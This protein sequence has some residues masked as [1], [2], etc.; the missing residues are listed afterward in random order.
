[1]RENDVRGIGR[2]P[3]AETFTMRD[4]ESAMLLEVMP[5]VVIETKEHATFARGEQRL[6]ASSISPAELDDRF[7]KGDEE[8]MQA[9]ALAR[10]LLR[11]TDVE[12]IRPLSIHQE[13]PGSSLGRPSSGTA[14]ADVSREIWGWDEVRVQASNLSCEPSFAGGG[15]AAIPDRRKGGGGNIELH[16][17]EFRRRAN[18]YMHA[19][20]G[21][22]SSATEINNA[23]GKLDILQNVM[24]K[25]AAVEKGS[26]V[27]GNNFPTNNSTSAQS[28]QGNL[29]SRS[30]ARDYEP[31]TLESLLDYLFPKGNEAMNITNE[32]LLSL[33]GAV[34]GLTLSVPKSGDLQHLI[35]RVTVT[36]LPSFS[37]LVGDC[38]PFVT[39]NDVENGSGKPI[40][41]AC[42]L[43]QLVSCFARSNLLEAIFESLELSSVVFNCC[44]AVN[45]NV[46]DS[47]D[48]S[49]IDR[50]AS[51]RIAAI[52]LNSGVLLSLPALKFQ[53]CARTLV[54][55][56]AGIIAASHLDERAHL[57]AVG[58][59]LK[60]FKHYAELRGVVLSLSIDSLWVGMSSS[61]GSFFKFDFEG[62]EDRIG[63]LP[64]VAVSCIQSCCD[65]FLHARSEQDYGDMLLWSNHFWAHIFHKW[66]SMQDPKMARSAI[67]FLVER[68]LVARSVPD[69][70]AADTLLLVM[71]KHLSGPLGLNNQ[72]VAVRSIAVE[73]LSSIVV[74]LL[75]SAS[76]MNK[77]DLVECP[78][79]ISYKEAPV[80]PQ[81]D[82][83][84][85]VV[86]YLLFYTSEELKKCKRNLRVM[87]A[88]NFG[89]DHFSAIRADFLSDLVLYYKA[90]MG[91]G[92][93]SI[94][95]D[96]SPIVGHPNRQSA[97][98]A[99]NSFMVDSPLAKSLDALLQSIIL[100]TGDINANV[101]SKTLKCLRPILQGNGLILLSSNGDAYTP[102]IT[103]LLDTS[104]SVREAA[105]GL[106]GESIAAHFELVNLHL[107]NIVLRLVDSSQNVRRRCIDVLADIAAQQPSVS[108]K[109]LSS[110][111]LR[112]RDPEQSIRDQVLNVFARLWFADCAKGSRDVQYIA[113][114]DAMRLS[115]TSL[116]AE[117]NLDIVKFASSLI[118][119]LHVV[120]SNTHKLLSEVF[121]LIFARGNSTCCSCDAF[122][123][124]TSLAA[125]FSVVC[126]HNVSLAFSKCSSLCKFVRDILAREA[127][128]GEESEARLSGEYGSAGSTRNILPYMNILKIML[129]ADHR[130]SEGGLAF[131]N[132][133]IVVD[134]GDDYEAKL[135]LSSM[136]VLEKSL[137][138]GLS[139][140]EE[141]MGTLLSSLQR[142]ILKSPHI[143]VIQTCA[144]LLCDFERKQACEGLDSFSR[145]KFKY[146][147][148][149]ATAFLNV[150]EKSR[151]PEDA[152]VCSR[153][154]LFR[155]L[156]VVGLL[157]RYHYP[158]HCY[159]VRAGA[160]RSDKCSM[161]HA[162]MQGGG[163]DC[164]L[165][166]YM[167]YMKVGDHE[168]RCRAVQGF[169]YLIV[170]RPLLL[171][172]DSVKA[173]VEAS[174]I[175]TS[176]A[177]IKVQA[178]KTL[179]DVVVNIST[180]GIEESSVHSKSN[181]AVGLLSL[182]Q[183]P[184]DL[185]PKSVGIDCPSSIP[186]RDGLHIGGFD[187]FHI[188]LLASFVD[189]SMSLLSDNSMETRLCALNLVETLILH[190][191]INPTSAISPLLMCIADESEEIVQRSSKLLSF[192]AQTH[193][194][195][196]QMRAPSDIS[197]LIRANLKVRSHVGE[198]LGLH[199]RSDL[200]LGEGRGFFGRILLAC[201]KFYESFATTRASRQHFV[202][203]IVKN[204]EPVGEED[205]GNATQNKNWDVE[206]IF[207][208]CLAHVL[209]VLPFKDRAE[210]LA[211]IFS[212]NNVLALHAGGL[213]TR[214]KSEARTDVMQDNGGAGPPY[215][216][217]SVQNICGATLPYSLLLMLKQ[218]L[219]ISF[220]IT[221][222]DV[223]SYRPS[224]KADGGK[225]A[226]R[227]DTLIFD[228]S[229]LLKCA[230]GSAT[231]HEAGNSVAALQR[232]ILFKKLMKADVDCD[233]GVQA[234]PAGFVVARRGRVDP[235]LEQTQGG[236]L[237]TSQSI[238]TG[239][240]AKRTQMAALVPQPLRVQPKRD[241]KA[242]F[243]Y[244]GDSS[245]VDAS[246]NE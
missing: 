137:S 37:R 95:S 18:S 204:F 180:V 42:T 236:P 158:L 34:H 89:E 246:E 146:S 28:G 43:L 242:K 149:L 19:G 29:G 151:N 108:A 163:V 179:L 26:S 60:M 183:N 118:N 124:G 36:D 30:K 220:D 70:P 107:D 74:H 10:E 4:K 87:H 134:S 195:F 223:K 155:A 81:L 59:L 218:F 54:G 47:T 55:T 106:L 214:L 172:D 111:L 178:L 6:L 9:M 8:I 148:R 76:V 161:C 85:H 1:M 12:H 116:S 230:S 245:D 7:R 27:G 147:V 208:N 58:A 112:I 69:W 122:S 50:A 96:A 67:I 105:V 3:Q 231:A 132:A 130:F 192:V 75:E 142:C 228:T 110:V 35:L 203:V 193:L 84:E 73:A 205:G 154:N 140:I 141:D 166:I 170:H 86:S 13:N 38:M 97:C 175:G 167:H 114:Y 72:H 227:D 181:A 168:L 139:W 22:R 117:E 79:T 184:A 182:L 31:I 52:V 68:L 88:W 82:S 120:D 103:R 221:E 186:D 145:D 101:R 53:D 102:I 25:L 144:K 244:L 185:S 206:L 152:K 99:T 128:Y 33:L 24:S 209:S 64:M 125:D 21:P 63:R 14:V 235:Y 177:K 215:N 66:L 44:E 83:R 169:F 173:V 165:P 187:G 115:Q 232:F 133:Y 129:C 65:E 93:D 61:S 17:D 238:I 217:A 171:N 138:S 200:A 212:I 197:S 160:M 190:G 5:E 199:V 224:D 202:G 196:I 77:S 127:Q 136:E 45:K 207:L 123:K 153:P 62:Q 233:F 94:S 240:G 150:L 210:P 48:R 191:F 194:R 71:C 11:G 126:K 119:L 109:I 229:A 57:H 201:C 174:L 239:K 80:L 16:A 39:K 213:L 234:L 243:T 219:K 159:F 51:E 98:L 23:E 32:T 91:R 46:L 222:S 15:G 131:L 176:D 78:P 198:F 135:L 237:G 40:L 121:A 90:Q 188:G 241:R 216:D 100:A 104:V 113:S 20:I 164:V 2:K 157:F 49:A 226:E 143:S 156:I 92:T 41:A 225:I 56:C 162:F 189:S 211:L